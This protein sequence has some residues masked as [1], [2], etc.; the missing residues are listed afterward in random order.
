VV[1]LYVAGRHG[2]IYVL[3][4][5]NVIGA[6]DKGK[7]PLQLDLHDRKIATVHAHPSDVNVF[8][9]FFDVEK[10]IGCVKVF[11]CTWGKFHPEPIPQIVTN[12]D[13]RATLLHK[14]TLVH[15]KKN[16]HTKRARKAMWGIGCGWGKSGW[17]IVC[18]WVVRGEGGGRCENES[19]CRGG[20]AG[21]TGVE[22]C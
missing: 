13:F 9:S 2:D 20:G 5:S 7:P 16:H 11:A 4:P 22:K 14:K 1:R 15:K 3:D 18:I 8:V 10:G 21:A 12:G 19:H 6:G 17:Q